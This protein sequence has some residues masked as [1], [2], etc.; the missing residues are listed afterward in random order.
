MKLRLFLLLFLAC[1]LLAGRAIAQGCSAQPIPFPHPGD[2]DRGVKS[3]TCIANINVDPDATGQGGRLR[4]D[5]NSNHQLIL[6]DTDDGG[7]FLWC[8]PDRTNG[9]CVQG[10]LLCLQQDGNMVIYE[11]NPHAGTP[12]CGDVGNNPTLG[13]AL[14]ASNTPGSN[15]G[16]EE[17]LVDEDVTWLE[18]KRYG[19][20]V[21]IRNGRGIQW[22][23]TGFS[24]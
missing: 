12:H 14:W 1:T 15:D 3:G 10:L 6:W 19:E 16:H 7:Q 21:V 11:G 17:L 20:R 18:L 2:N 9:I 23:S 5:D 24:D 22:V 13:N 8:A 4:W